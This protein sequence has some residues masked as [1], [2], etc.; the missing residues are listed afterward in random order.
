MP[1]RH[2]NP[3]ATFAAKTTQAKMVLSTAWPAG[4]GEIAYASDSKQAYIA[5]D[6][7]SAA[8]WMPIPT[9]L[10]GTIY[11]AQTASIATTA[12]LTPS[13]DGVYRLSYYLEIT[14]AGISGTLSVVI[15]WT[16]EN[17]SQ[18]NTPVNGVTLAATGYNQGVIV[19][20]AKTSGSINYAVT[21]TTAV[22]SPVYS[23]YLF[24]ERLF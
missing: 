5:D 6:P 19:M 9:G 22:G 4:I 13:V 15:G 24:L 8:T 7:T 21:L 12:L 3:D 18:T 2:R 11:A 1:S 16:D 10:P 17:G 14:T 23:L 20:R